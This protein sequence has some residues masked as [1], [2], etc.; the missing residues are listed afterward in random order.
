MLYQLSYARDAEGSITT[1]RWR[2]HRRTHAWLR[3]APTV[4]CNS[5]MRDR[6]T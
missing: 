5:R 6:K 1:V 2:V 3:A 4:S